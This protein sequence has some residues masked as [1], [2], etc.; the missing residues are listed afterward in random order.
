TIFRL[1]GCSRRCT[2]FSKFGDSGFRGDTYW[3]CKYTVWSM[4]MQTVRH[5]CPPHSPDFTW[6]LLSFVRTKRLPSRFEMRRISSAHAAPPG[7]LQTAWNTSISSFV[8]PH[9]AR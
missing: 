1:Q 7:F 3:S 4:I 8:S 9:L 2:H 6:Y 5:A